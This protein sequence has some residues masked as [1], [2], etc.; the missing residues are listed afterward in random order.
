MYAC[1]AGRTTD[2]YHNMML[3]QFELHLFPAIGEKNIADIE[4]KKLFD[5]FC[6]IAG[7]MNA[8]GKP[9]IYMTKKLCQ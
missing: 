4:G 2:D 1:K 3:R 9:M 5:L 7:K 8:R 6:G